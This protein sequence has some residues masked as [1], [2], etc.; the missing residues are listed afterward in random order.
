MPAIDI[1]GQKFGKLLVLE[2]D[3][4]KIGDA[5]YWLCQCDCGNIKSIR[6][7]NLRANK[8]P[9]RSCG[10]CITKPENIDMDSEIGN[11]YGRLTVL[12][13]DLLKPIGH[14]NSAYWLCQC[15]CGNIVSVCG[16]QL[17]S[18]KTK[19]CGCLKT[20]MLRMRSTLDLTDQRF[21]KLI[22]LSSTKELSEDGTYNWLCQCDCGNICC[23]SVET[24]NSNKA[25]S[26][27]CASKSNGE[28]KIQQI[29][30]ENNISFQEQYCFS[31]LKGKNN[32]NLRYDF[33][34]LDEFGRP[35]RLIEFDGEQHYN[36]LSKF[37]SERGIELDNIKNNYARQHNYPLI[38]I[39]YTE[40]HNLS[41]DLLLGDKYLI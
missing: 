15:D 1:T 27:G 34:I 6:G 11:R 25:T 31:D 18:Q 40:L 8:Q 14:H 38:R 12:K 13:R 7:T 26:C 35:V 36:P 32:M 10:K 20:E 23:Y 39:P 2:R 29:L 4:E 24:L 5:A 21:G 30:K 17:R 37:Y 9:T 41:L 33:A 16:T 28:I 22:A 19:S 3:K